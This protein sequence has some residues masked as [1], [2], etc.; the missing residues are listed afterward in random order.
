MSIWDLIVIVVFATFLIT[1]MISGI[2]FRRRSIDPFGKPPVRRSIFIPG[3]AAMFCCW[4]VLFL[5]A[6]GVEVPQVRLPVWFSNT[7]VIIATTGMVF[8]IM[9]FIRLGNA[10]RFGFPEDSTKLRTGGI[11][12]ISRNPMYVGFFLLC[13]AAVIRVP[14]LFVLLCAIAVAAVHHRIV[15]AEETFLDG[16]F[17]QSWWVYS[18]RVRRY[19]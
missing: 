5:E 15:L 6:I 8:I 1:V 9:S 11:Y 4:T 13:I 16:R 3:K 18:G 12:R 14:N 17:G 10:N 19:L 2:L 7:G